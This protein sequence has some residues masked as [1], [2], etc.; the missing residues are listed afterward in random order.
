ML[1]QTANEPRS[2]P[3][4]ADAAFGRRQRGEGLIEILIAVLVLAIG[5]LGI[6]ALQTRALVGA[7]GSMGRS[8]ATVALYSIS[9]AMMADATNARSGAY[10]GQISADHCPAA[11]TLAETQINAWC[12]TLATNL[13]ADATTTGSINCT[14][15]G[16]CSIAIQW[17]DA[18]DSQAEADGDS[19]TLT[20]NIQLPGGA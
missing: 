8:M 9:D 10:N 7:G 11:G 3:P 15:D 6:A 1:Q 17:V 12:T 4:H 18:R 5:I 2:R 14:A 19:Q 20:T 16:A 13:G